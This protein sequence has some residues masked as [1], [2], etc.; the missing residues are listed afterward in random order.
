MSHVVAVFTRELCCLG[1]LPI[2]PGMLSQK[3]ALIAVA[4][5]KVK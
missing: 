4:R 5:G 3:E 2:V 1:A